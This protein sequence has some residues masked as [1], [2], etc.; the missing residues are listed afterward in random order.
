MHCLHIP[1][2]W[3]LIFLY[4]PNKTG[5]KGFGGN[6]VAHNHERGGFMYMARQQQYGAQFIYPKLLLI[7]IWKY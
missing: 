7:S 3:R 1:H 2:P 6:P 4:H 5:D